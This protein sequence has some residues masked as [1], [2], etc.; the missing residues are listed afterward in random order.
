MTVQGFI[1][2]LTVPN[3]PLTAKGRVVS[4]FVSANSHDLAREME[5]LR[6]E[7]GGFYSL[8][9]VPAET[10]DW[11]LPFPARQSLSAPGVELTGRETNIATS[12]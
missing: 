9:Y 11:E 2:G 4:L 12:R 6:R 10:P 1:R 8:S 7:A 3:S 5:R